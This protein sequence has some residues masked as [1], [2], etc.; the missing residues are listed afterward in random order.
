MTSTGFTTIS[1]VAQAPAWL[2]TLTNMVRHWTGV[3][4]PESQSLASALDWEVFDEFVPNAYADCYYTAP[5]V[6]KS[7]DAPAR[8]YGDIVS[9]LGPGETSGVAAPELQIDYRAS[10]ASY[11]GFE[12]WSVGVVEFRYMTGRI[13]VDTT[14]GKPVISAFRPTIDSESRDENGTLTVDGSGSGSVT[15]TTPF[16]TT[17][18]LQLTPQG[19]GD[20]TASYV[21]LTTT[22]F[23][24]HFKTAGVASAGTMSYTAT[25]V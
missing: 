22:G 23:T 20:V 4:T 8:I 18:A 11:D 9:V 6:D 2:G 25:G 21:S 14:V 12:N 13:H 3:L 16:H 19:S 5:E 17:P 1:S 10:S 24:G 7:I 15:F